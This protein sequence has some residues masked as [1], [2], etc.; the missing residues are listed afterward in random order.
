MRADQNID[1][2]FFK[3]LQNLFGLRG[4]F[5]TVENF[6][7]YPKALK[8]LSGIQKMLLAEHCGWA[9]QRHLF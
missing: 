5:E 7:P 6:D 1:L 3:A 2:A 9:E 8:P 4:G